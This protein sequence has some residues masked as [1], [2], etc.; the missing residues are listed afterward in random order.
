[1]T[2]TPTLDR[3]IEAIAIGASAGGIDALFKLLEP[4]PAGLRCPLLAV[5]HLPAGHESRLSGIF[6]ARLRIAVREATP[7][8]TAEPGTLYF[9]PP[10]YHLLVEP[11]R[12]L[13]LSCEP[14][15]CFSRPSI[16]VLFESCA[17]AWGERLLAIVLT[18]ANDDGA[19]GLARVRELGGLAAVQDPAE[20]AH[21]QM[22]QSALEHAGADFV[23]PLDRLR[24]LLRSA[25]LP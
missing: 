16:D 4:L 6:G 25:A 14:P 5:I 1:M 21:P 18:G 23:L 24:E 20:A 9:A 10:D 8:A 12:T 11:D 3:P 2:P 17:E 15:V 22:P 13:S 19:E 7:G